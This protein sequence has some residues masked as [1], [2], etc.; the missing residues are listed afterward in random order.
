MDMGGMTMSPTMAM[1]MATT[2]T[3][4]AAVTTTAINMSD[5]DMGGMGENAHHCKISVRK[6]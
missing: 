6:F 4:A 1:P 5:M 3:T 2:T